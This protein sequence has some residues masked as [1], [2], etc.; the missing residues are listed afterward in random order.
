[1]Y[2][3]SNTAAKLLFVET[4]YEPSLIEITDKDGAKMPCSV[5]STAK[6]G[7]VWLTTID[8]DSLEQ[9][10]LDHPTLY[11]LKTDSET[12]R[13]GHTSV[14]TFQNKHILLNDTPVYVR[15][16]I[17]GIVAHDH[18][19]MTGESD[20]AA[21]VKN[22]KQM[23]KYGFNLVRFHSRIPSEDFVRAADELGLL[24]HM[25]L[26]YSLDFS[27]GN[28]LIVDKDAW[29]ATILRYR[30]NPSVVI[31]CL[32]N[33]LSVTRLFPEVKGL[34]EDGK[35]LAPHKLILDS[36][37]WGEYDRETAD[38]YSQHI[39]YFFPFKHHKDMFL[40]DDPWLINGSFYESP[41]DTQTEN[42]SA[43]TKTHRGVVPIRPTIAH[44]AIHYIDI[45]DYKALSKKFDE[46]VAK[47]G[48]EYVAKHKIKRPRYMTELPEL[49]HRKGLEDL[50]D[51]YIA[52]SRQWKL[53]GTK[54]YLE[55]LRLADS[56]CGY[57]M[58]QFSDCLKYENKN[59]IVDFFDD[60]KG[61]DSN[62]MRQMNGD[63]VLLTDMD[64]ETVYE[65]ES[66]R[67]NV[68]AS[69]FLP[70][71]EIRGDLQLFLDEEM[72]YE[73]KNY[74]LA[75]GLQKLADL[76]IQPKAVGY[77]KKH[78]LRARFTS[79]DL[80]VQN[81]WS[82][83]SYPR[84]VAKYSFDAAVENAR[85][86]DYV[87]KGSNASDVFVTDQLNETVFNKLDSGETVVLFYEHNAT[88]NT[89]QLPGALE[90]FKPCIWDRGSNL[91]GIL[92]TE[93]LQKALASERYFD[94]NLYGL[95]EAGSK[96]NLDTF[97][98]RVSEFISGIDKPVRDR[99]KGLV[100]GIKKFIDADTLRR[101]SHLFS[102]GVGK[103]TL[104][105]CSLN[106]SNPDHPVVS[107]FL[108]FL[109]ENIDSLKSDHNISV[110]ELRT[111]LINTN[112]AGIP[113]ED[114]QN[115]FWEIDCKLV[116]DVLFWEEVKLDL[117]TF[118]SVN[119][120]TLE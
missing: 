14:S 48:E 13:F 34:Y 79:G 119:T 57:E 28:K 1:M 60:D 71:P 2:I 51:D 103:G 62:W 56:L 104:I 106:V 59:G 22:I 42:G 4:D 27:D 21:A 67:I 115:H 93:A 72:I 91:G 6:K 95:L 89:W 110:E 17:R 61:I 3:Y 86:N 11:T 96:V 35:N 73:G 20:Y 37:G 88:R 92:H 31:F 9:W 52:G 66:F 65:D 85:L 102:V 25:E 50:M 41:I 74:L 77:A 100:A 105:V 33:E 47:V 94:L 36:S 112:E 45:P 40:K 113:K 12:Q 24:I 29:R 39:A 16:C 81:N 5:F 82:I 10:H 101:F 107:S 78:I 69:D 58:L 49:I 44:E 63:L 75:G 68:Y 90:R 99:M 15:G 114:I 30:N 23:K 43:V 111:W 7:D 80:T 120:E 8:A 64:I 98:C 97:P 87:T 70:K 18:P 108:N 26:G 55:Q 32:G 118:E 38:I 54:V 19:N 53:M 84:L 83:W 116:E 117:A 76:E 109:F 46:F